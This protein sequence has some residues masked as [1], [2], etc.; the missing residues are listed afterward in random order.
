MSRGPILWHNVHTF[1]AV[2]SAFAGN[3]SRR[4]AAEERLGRSIPL[5]SEEHKAALVAGLIRRN[6]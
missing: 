5:L 4:K 6:E 1:A 3:V 2:E